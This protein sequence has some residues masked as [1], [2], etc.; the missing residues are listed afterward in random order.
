MIWK[1]LGPI[2][3]TGGVVLVACSSSDTEKYPSPDAFCAAKAAEECKKAAASCAVTNDACNTAR[4]NACTSAAN[5]ALAQGRAYMSGQADDCIAK[6][7]VAF[8]DPTNK[9]KRDEWVA[10]C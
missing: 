8:D 5:A 2:V 4:K 3:I 1:T 7:T 10:A 9:D 6:T